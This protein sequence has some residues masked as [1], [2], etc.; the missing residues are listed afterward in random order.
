VLLCTDLHAENVLAA[1][2]EP[3]LAIDPK[4]CIGDPAFDAIQH[5]LNC[6]LERKRSSV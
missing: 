5:M 1:E 2:R 4:P 3:W 6:S